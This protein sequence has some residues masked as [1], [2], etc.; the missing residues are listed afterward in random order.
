MGRGGGLV[1]AVFLLD[2]ETVEG[3]CDG[4]GGSVELSD[5]SPKSIVSSACGVVA[6]SSILCISRPGQTLLRECRLEVRGMVEL[7]M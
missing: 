2:L 4:G 1:M 6:G 3:R 5:G 7:A